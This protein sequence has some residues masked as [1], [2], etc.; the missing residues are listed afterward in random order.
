MHSRELLEILRF[1]GASA[2]A[3]TLFDSSRWMDLRAQTDKAHLT[4]ALRDALDQQGF[5]I[6][7]EVRA[8]IEAA[9]RRNGER[10]RRIRAAYEEIADGFRQRGLEHAVL[11]GFSHCSDFCPEPQLR[12]QYDLDLWLAPGTAAESAEVALALGYE[13]IEGMERYPTDHLPTMLRRTGWRWRG[14]LYD[15]EIPPGVEIHFRL[16]D[17]RTERF[18]PEGIE[19]FW[20]RREMARLGDFEF[21]ALARA[22]RLGYACLHLLRHVLRGDVRPYHVYEIARFL[23]VF[24][25]DAEFWAEWKTLHSPSLRSTE[26]IVF[27]IAREWFRCDLAPAAEH[28]IG[29][30][31]GDV[32]EWIRLYA[33]SPLDGGKKSELWLHLNL[34][35]GWRDRLAIVRRRLLPLRIPGPGIGV[36]VRESER[37]A[38]LRF[39]MR[40]SQ[41]RR[42]ADRS[43]HHAGSLAPTA[44]E[45]FGWWSKTQ[46]ISDGFWRFLGAALLF[47][48][49][50]FVFVL[51][52]NIYLAGGELGFGEGAIGLFHSAFTTG[53]LTGILP[54]A[55]LLRRFPANRAIAGCFL[56]VALLGTLRSMTG[57]EPALAV[58]AFLFGA[59]LS[60]WAVSVPPVVAQL[61][62]ERGRPLAFSLF[63]GTGIGI[64]VVAGPIGGSLPKWLAA[65]SVP[66]PTQGALLAACGLIALAAFPAWRLRLAAVSVEKKKTHAPNEFLTRFLIAISAWSL[67]T[68]IFNPFF[69]VFFTKQLGFSTQE[70]GWVFSASQGF[71]VA[72]IL[73]APWLFR[74]WGLSNGIGATQVLTALALGALALGPAAVAVP[75]YASYMMFQFMSEPGLFT[76]LTNNVNAANHSG[77]SA[78]YF[79]FAHGAQAL[80]AAAAG[81]AILQF[82]YPPTLVVAA[83]FVLISAVLFRTLVASKRQTSC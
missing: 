49:G 66:N 79:F 46:G 53:S 42:I 56:A 40:W 11:K 4:F 41:A 65:L 48:A 47:N 45:G 52:Y 83:V 6:P 20:E 55:T 62:D 44:L 60:V 80:A 31:G 34:V 5:P 12:L 25:G 63:A 82:G 9:A 30:L 33:L 64:G 29:A 16:W 71:Q 18:A 54:A 7:G 51:L 61:A 58:L 23:H 8:S 19:A 17:G 26:A 36:E 2:K 10:Y 57:S 69:N 39:R 22:D 73:A 59:A 78:R 15:P 35:T 28:A 43:W 27:G 24:A 38:A 76:M 1:R 75:A 74:R 32:Q 72:A 37:S 77:A 21:P 81:K 68:G 3:L 67:A 50:L 70:M 13:P 14:D